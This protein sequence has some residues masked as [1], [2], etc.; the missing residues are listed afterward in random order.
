MIKNSSDFGACWGS[1]TQQH[2]LML[3]R[4]INIDSDDDA[5]DA[6]DADEDE[7]LQYFAEYP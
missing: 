5:D 1:L 3:H 7:L 2:K 4:L 6:D